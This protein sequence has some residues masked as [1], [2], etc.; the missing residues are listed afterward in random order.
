M[1][2]YDARIDVYIEKAAPFAQPI[3]KHIRRVVHEVSPLITESVKWGMPFFE[4]KGPLCQMASFKQHL[5]FG[6]W[7]ASRLNDPHHFL[8]LGGEESA[9]GSF[10]RL[11]K[12]EDLPSE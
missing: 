3:L 2:Q 11:N 1:E 6:F 10:G 12:I 9:A 4:Y 8:S 7:R 5:G